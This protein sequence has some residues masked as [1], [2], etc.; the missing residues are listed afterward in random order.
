MSPLSKLFLGPARSMPCA[1]CGTRL[2]VRGLLALVAIVPAVLALAFALGGV[3]PWPLA[4]GVML[5]DAFVFVG[6]VPLVAR[7]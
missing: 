1:H 5:I 7:S 4:L 6:F 2:G 3:L